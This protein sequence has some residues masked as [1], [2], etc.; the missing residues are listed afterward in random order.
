MAI[1]VMIQI[2]AIAFP[3][4]FVLALLSFAI[5]RIPEEQPPISKKPDPSMVR[6]VRT[7]KLQPADPMKRFPRATPGIAAVAATYID[8]SDR[9]VA[10]RK[11]RKIVPAEFKAQFL[12]EHRM[13]CLVAI[14]Q[15]ERA[16]DDLNLRCGKPKGWRRPGAKTREQRIAELD[17]E[18]EG[19][20]RRENS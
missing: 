18:I 15:H 20:S 8:E 19:I 12:A 9:V 5:V 4:L 14:E 16:L 10:A 17:E 1:N 6:N 11:L 13:R 3:A 7:G 2:A